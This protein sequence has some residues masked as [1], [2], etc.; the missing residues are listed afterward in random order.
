MVTNSEMSKYEKLSVIKYSQDAS[1]NASVVMD[2]YEMS[3]SKG[4]FK[5]NNENKTGDED[6]GKPQN[7]GYSIT[8]ASL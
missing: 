3:Q 2:N 8:I 4:K 7:N 5:L 1:T 6:K